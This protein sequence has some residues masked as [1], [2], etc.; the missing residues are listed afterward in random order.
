M[1]AMEMGWRVDNQAFGTDVPSLVRVIIGCVDVEAGAIQMGG[2]MMRSKAGACNGEEVGVLG[3]EGEL[4]GAATCGE[5]GLVGAA[6]CSEMGTAA[7]C[8]GLPQDCLVKTHDHSVFPDDLNDLEYHEMSCGASVLDLNCERDKRIAY[9]SRRQSWDAIA[10][11]ADLSCGYCHKEEEKETPSLDFEDDL[12]GFGLSPSRHLSRPLSKLLLPIIGKDQQ[13]LAR[14]NLEEVTWSTDEQSPMQYRSGC[15]SSKLPLHGRRVLTTQS[16][17]KSK[18]QKNTPASNASTSASLEASSNKLMFPKLT[19]SPLRR[20]Q[21]LDSDSD[22]P[23]ASEDI[24][25]YNNKT[26]LSAKGTQYNLNKSVTM[27]QQKRPKAAASSMLQTEDLWRDFSPKKTVNVP[28]PA[29][30]EFCEEYFKSVKAKNVAQRLDDGVCVSNLKDYNQRS[31]I[32]KN[33]EPDWDMANPLPPAHHYFFHDDPRIQELVRSR[34]PNFSPLGAVNNRGNKQS[35]VS[36]IDYMDQFGQ[37]EEGLMQHGTGKNGLEG[38][39]KRGRKNSKNVNVKEGPQVSGNWVTPKSCASIPKDAG[40]RRVHADGQSA[41]HWYT[42]PEGRKVYVT[43]NGQELTGQIA[44]R[45]YR[46]ESKTGF[47]R[48][49]KKATAKKKSKR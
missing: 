38:R 41:G 11:E 19:I 45:H 46:K 34:L 15:S 27:N 3:D 29:L 30:D 25:R 21:L 22:D 31:N 2:W 7:T 24:H 40:K 44:Y 18:A 48:S 28:T 43:K 17:S 35:D 47:K 37:R 14:Q 49:K 42:G 36:V 8:S 39:S 1:K 5:V 9:R 10:E 26:D 33:L 20:F 12:S 16:V 23:S 4:G 32:S 13:A 6:T